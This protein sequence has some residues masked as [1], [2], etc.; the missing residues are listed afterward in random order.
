MDN[1][2]SLSNI[3]VY[4]KYS[5]T[6]I[7]TSTGDSDES[8]SYMNFDSYLKLLVSQMQ[9]Q[10]FNDPM[11]DS[12]VL[13]QMAQYSMLEGIKNMTQ[14]NNIS[15]STS[16]VGKVVTVSDGYDYYTGKVESVTVTNGEPK[17]MIDG[18]GYDC[19]TVSDIVS[20][21]V[22][23]DLYSMVGK[24]VK[25]T[26]T[27]ETGKVT[28]VIFLS[29]ESYVVLNG[30]E[31]VP[32]S[33]VEV[34]KAAE[35]AETENSTETKEE[36]VTVVTDEVNGDKTASEP[37]EE[38][39]T[40][41]TEE[42]QSYADKSQSLIDDFMKELDS[43]DEANGVSEV[44]ET[45]AASEVN[46]EQY[47]VETVELEVPDYSAGVY[48]DTS[49]LTGTVSLKNVD[50]TY[51]SG[52]ITETVNLNPETAARTT[53]GKLKGVTTAPSVSKSDCVPHRISVEDYPEEA[54]LADKLGTRMYDIR[55]IHN[56][57]I[58][59][60]IKT[61]EVI[62]HTASG[63]AITEI[64]YSGVGQLG[65]VV[66]FADGTQRV[67]VLLKSGNST[68]I[69]TSGNL[70][71]D[72]IC[73]REWAPGSLTGKLTPSEQAIRHFS[74]PTANYDK[75]ALRAFNNYLQSRGITVVNPV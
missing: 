55:F 54:A 11:K 3:G 20:D 65:E 45:S 58:T 41:V 57:A 43:I 26:L 8:N 59:S 34:V 28:D 27:G 73:T 64:G 18:K 13:N 17:L 29:G 60:R 39:V 52:T 51:G 35:K 71:L 21:D 32:L 14:Q 10:D 68:W 6:Y 22:Y 75:S 36:N 42:V 23:K 66:T 74:D 61:D 37:A 9:N 56:T 19:K 25:I 15:Y 33:T 48:A 5:N 24:D 69:T 31:A 12:E 38:N 7:D 16:L 44:S 47:I 40:V 53:E 30:K 49:V 50:N 1:S 63:K 70:T 46:M 67:E 4:S 72:E 2:L 62:G